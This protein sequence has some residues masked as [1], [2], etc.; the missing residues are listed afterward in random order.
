MLIGTACDE[1][2]AVLNLSCNC[3]STAGGM[4]MESKKGIKQVI[5]WEI[6]GR[7]YLLNLPSREHYQHL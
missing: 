7:F 6:E 4:Q 2:Q 3:M 1:R 5:C